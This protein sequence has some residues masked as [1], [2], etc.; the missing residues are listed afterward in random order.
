[1]MS[2]L[3]GSRLSP[4]S[5][6]ASVDEAGPVL[7]FVQA[8]L[9]DLQQMSESGEGDVGQRSALEGR[10]GPFDPIEV[11]SVRRQLE[12]LQPRLRAGEGAQLCAEMDS[13]V[14]PGGGPGPPDS[15]DPSRTLS[16]LLPAAACVPTRRL[17]S[18]SPGSCD[19]PAAESSHLHSIP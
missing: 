4:G 12:H 1:M 17:P 18:A 6:E 9:D 8:V 19:C 2:L 16:G 13:E 3:S 7:D 14:G 10:P 5:G 11:G 15:A